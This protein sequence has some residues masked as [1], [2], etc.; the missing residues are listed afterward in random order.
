[1]A[2]KPWWQLAHEASVF[3]DATADVCTGAGATEAAAL[4][5]GTGALGATDATG[6][7]ALGAALAL[8]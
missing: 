8:A 7:D 3:A 5:P 2:L 1:L 6:A 4:G